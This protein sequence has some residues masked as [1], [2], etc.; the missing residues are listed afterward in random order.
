MKDTVWTPGVSNH[1]VSRAVERM[2][3]TEDE[4]REIGQNLIWAIQNERWDVVEFIGRVSRDGNRV[5][6]FRWAPTGRRWYA[7]INTKDLVCITVLTPG[8]QVR[9]EGKGRLTLKEEW[10]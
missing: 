7:L 1:F 10:L 8:F 6:R 5:F 3:C 9:R 4:A 2:G